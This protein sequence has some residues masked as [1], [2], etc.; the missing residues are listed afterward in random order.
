MAMIK[1]AWEIALE[2]T[3]D[4]EVDTK[5][6]A[7]AEAVQQGRKLAASFLNDDDVD[8][9]TIKDTLKKAQPDQKKLLVQG[10][11]VASL[12]NISLPQSKDYKGQFSRLTKLVTIIGNKD[13]EG[14]VGQLGQFFDQYLT[15]QDQLTER[16]KQQYQPKLEQKQEQLRQQ[17]GDDVTLKPEQDPDF[18]KMLSQ[19]LKQLDAQYGQA[20]TNAKTQV[21][22]LFNIE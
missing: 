13:Y 10:L 5:K 12:D 22:Q 20:V 14:L 6:Y 19:L 4:I 11:V 8:E 15:Q 16:A 1:S 2:K 21:R 17:Y 9:K 18:L 7:Q 3:K